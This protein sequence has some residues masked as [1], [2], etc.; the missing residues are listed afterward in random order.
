MQRR[1]FIAGT[2]AA[3]TGLMAAPMFVSGESSESGVLRVALVGCGRQGRA[4]INAGLMIPNLRFTAVCDIHPTVLRSARLYLDAEDVE[5]NAYPDFFEMLEKERKNLD[6]VI[7]ATP[8]FAHAEESIAAMEAGLH[9]YCHPPMATNPEDARKMIQTARSKN[10]LLQIAF[11][12]RSDPRYRHVASRLLRGEQAGKFLG[13]ITHFETQMNRRVRSELIWTERDTLADK[14]LE[15]YGYVSMREYK[16]WRQY[17]KYGQGPCMLY[18][19]Q[20]LDVLHWFYGVKPNNVQAMGGLDY[21]NFG[22]RMDN[23]TALLSYPFPH[24]TVR[25]LSRVWTTTSGG[26]NLPFEHVY[27]EFGSMQTSSSETA[28]RA[29]AEPGLAQWENFVRSGDLQKAVTAAEGED[30]NLIRVRETGH[31]VSYIVPIKRPGSEIQVHLENFVHA[32]FD[33]EPLNCPGEEAFASHIIAWKV[34]EAAEK[35]EPIKLTEEMFCVN[36]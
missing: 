29:H 11:E 22:D 4:V 6:A 14:T 15:K 10:K 3:G 16:N 21:Y 1:D 33:K 34:N 27:G 18:L 28:F 30:P 17:H 12:H 9:V 25:G 20:P 32:A 35:G 8:D 31:V 36:F 24:G 5:V 7:V 26:G 13:R 2:L 19:A 23:I